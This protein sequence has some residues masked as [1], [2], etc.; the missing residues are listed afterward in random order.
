MSA[1]YH[2]CPQAV[3][4]NQSTPTALSWAIEAFVCERTLGHGLSS[5]GFPKSRCFFEAP[6]KYLKNTDVPGPFQM[7]K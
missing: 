2:M 4:K 6:S 1:F 5:P 3:V 7:L